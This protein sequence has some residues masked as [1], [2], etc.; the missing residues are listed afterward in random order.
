MKHRSVRV[1]ATLLSVLWL[2]LLASCGAAASP[3]PTPNTTAPPTSSSTPNQYRGR[4]PGASGTLTKINGNILIL[5]TAQGTVTVNIGSNTTIQKTT[6][7]ALSDLQEGESLLVT[8]NPD[9]SGNISA[10]SIQVQ[11]QGW[12]PPSPSPG[13]NRGP[14]N[15]NINR[16][17]RQRQ[18]V[19]GT[20]SKIEG[21][22]LTLTT[23]Q[24]TATVSVGSDTTI[25]ETVTG[26]TSDLEEGQFL[27]V[28]GSRDADG[29][30]TATSI[31]IQPPGQ[32]APPPWAPPGTQ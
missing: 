17:P 25:Q 7:G 4:G 10:T 29:N 1:I 3:S 28:I 32:N 12:S 6:T 11:P 5:T 27:L 30:V 2:I 19:I 20:I 8:G 24:G 9:A 21:N 16:N 18:G 14:S 22:I 13:G 15:Q 23:S 26:T 31:R